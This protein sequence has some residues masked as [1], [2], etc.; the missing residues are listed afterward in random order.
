MGSMTAVQRASNSPEKAGTSAKTQ[1]IIY[2]FFWDPADVQ[3]GPRDVANEGM[4]KS[5]HPR[6]SKDL[7]LV[8]VSYKYQ[9]S[10]T[11]RA[12]YRIVDNSSPWPLDIVIG[13]RWTG[14]PGTIIADVSALSLTRPVAAVPLKHEIVI[15]ENDAEQA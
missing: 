13:P 2:N 5:Q 1:S 8:R 6:A 11:Q 15:A 4:A 7:W 10:A 12:L 14:N 9:G 3:L